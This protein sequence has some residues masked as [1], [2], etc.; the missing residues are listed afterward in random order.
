M[1]VLTW[2]RRVVPPG[3]SYG[4]GATMSLVEHLEELRDRLIRC[5]LAVVVTTTLAFVFINVIMSLLL[6]LAGNHVIQALDPTETFATYFK[7][8]I[9]AGLGLTMPVLVYQLLRF[10]APGLTRGEQRALYLSLPFVVLCFVTGALFCYFVIL[11]SALHFLLG[12]GDPRILKQISLTKFIG[13]VS[14]FI[15]AVGAAFELP[16]FIFMLAKLGIATYSRL[17]R[18]RKYAFLLSFVVAAIITPTP[19]PINQA[20][21]AVPLFLLYELGL[22]LSRF[23]RK[24]RTAA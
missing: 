13:F 21:V 24:P 23:A 12:F 10:L 7:V 1:S 14:N 4:P 17:A 6:D 2:K 3:K 9:T 15:L 11:P 19:D 22:Q 18:F 8:A 5:T 16:V 20:L